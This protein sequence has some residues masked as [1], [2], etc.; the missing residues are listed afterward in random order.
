MRKY[1]KQKLIRELNKLAEKLGRLPKQRDIVKPS[2]MAY[3]NAF[4]SFN[5]ALS[6]AGLE[7]KKII[8]Y[9]EIELLGLLRKRY[10]LAS[11]IPTQRDFNKLKGYPDSKTYYERFGSW[12]NALKAAGFK[13]NK[14]GP[15]KGKKKKLLKKQEALHKE[16][17]PEKEQKKKP[18]WRRLFG[19]D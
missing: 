1:P 2:L 19:S 15:K 18:L 17:I 14:P 11:K 16:K 13:P 9:T 12:N 3:R 5:K 7:P 10:S 8:S 4:G 6:G